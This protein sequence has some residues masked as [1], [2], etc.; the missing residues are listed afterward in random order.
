MHSCAPFVFVHS[1]EYT[2]IHAKHSR[3]L[4]HLT[5]DRAALIEVTGAH[6]AVRPLAIITRILETA[7]KAAGISDDTSCS[8]QEAVPS[9]AKEFKVREKLTHY[10]NRTEMHSGSYSEQAFRSAL[11]ELADVK[12]SGY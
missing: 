12:I 11:S 6:T 7:E 1:V 10:R 2:L 5:K 3:A 9:E 8:V 4:Y